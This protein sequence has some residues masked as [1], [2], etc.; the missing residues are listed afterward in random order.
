MLAAWE[1]MGRPDRLSKGQVRKLE[2]A[3]ILPENRPTLG[4][5]VRSFFRRR[6]RLLA[7]IAGYLTGITIFIV[8][9]SAFREL[10]ITTYIDYGEP[11]LVSRG[12]VDFEVSGYLSPL[13]LAGGLIAFFVGGIVYWVIYE[14]TLPLKD[15]LDYE[16]I[17]AGLVFYGV[18]G[19]IWF[20][21]F[22]GNKWGDF[23]VYILEIAT[24]A[25]AFFLFK[26]W[27]DRRLEDLTDNPSR[28]SGAKN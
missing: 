11:R 19:Q 27:R 2:W 13:G 21:L 26:K 10:G 8:S 24:A 16:A 25:L 7:E 3:E 6:R 23:F 14:G 4:N 18:V 15:R 22:Y 5:R 17:I 9:V 28:K 12:D 20:E 1:E